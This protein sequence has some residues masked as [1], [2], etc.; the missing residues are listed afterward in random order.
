MAGPRKPEFTVT[1]ED[2]ARFLKRGRALLTMGDVT[3][4]RLFLERASNA[5]LADAAMAIAETYDPETLP[6]LN[7]VGLAGDRAQ[8]RVW[9]LRAQALGSAAATERL[10]S[11]GGP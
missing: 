7:V 2:G 1:P 3:G 8:A 10:K 11:I 9:Y 6:R 5:G 4:A